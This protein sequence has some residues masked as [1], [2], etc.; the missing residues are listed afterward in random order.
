MTLEKSHTIGLYYLD[1]YGNEKIRV[2]VKDFDKSK[3]KIESEKQFKDF[4]IK[5]SQGKKRNR[6]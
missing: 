1:K 6:R 2:L 4:I 5:K 3:N